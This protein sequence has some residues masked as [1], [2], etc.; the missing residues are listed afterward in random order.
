M[1]KIQNY[2]QKL[3][4]NYRNLNHPLGIIIYWT[5]VDLADEQSTG[6]Q[7][8]GPGSLSRVCPST[9]FVATPQASQQTLQFSYSSA[10]L[11][12]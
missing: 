9:G 3:L 7:A 5:L 8:E 10:A 6:Q 4:N 1:K 11:E 2:W 12:W